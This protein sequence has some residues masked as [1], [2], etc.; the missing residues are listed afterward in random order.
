MAEALVIPSTPVDGVRVLAINRPSKRNALSSKLISVLLEQ[1]S[2]AAK[3]NAVRVIIITGTSTYFSAGADIKEISEMDAEAAQGCRYLSNLSDGMRAVRRPLIAAVEGM[4]LGGG[5]EVALMCA[6]IFA[7]NV[8]R[9]GLPEVTLG[10]IPG[11][12]GTQRLTNVLGKFKGITYYYYYY[13]C[14]W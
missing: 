12:G 9:F 2:T 7:S 4:A 13:Y 8:G 5:F 10:L 6:L 11:A 3:D 14:Q 1:L